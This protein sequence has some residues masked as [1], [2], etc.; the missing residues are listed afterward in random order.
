MG[1]KGLGD[2]VVIW[3]LIPKGNPSVKGGLG[4]KRR[5]P[6]PGALDPPRELGRERP[7]GTPRDETPRDHSQ[8][9]SWAERIQGDPA[10]AGVPEAGEPEASPKSRPEEGPGRRDANLGEAAAAQGV[11]LGTPP[12][13]CAPGKQTTRTGP[14]N[15]VLSHKCNE[16]K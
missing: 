8:Q 12:R 10:Q 11:S 5:L 14:L 3:A 16:M 4:D 6:G 9:R 1:R 7:R 13:F 15:P 2:G